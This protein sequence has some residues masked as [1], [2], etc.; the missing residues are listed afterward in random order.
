MTEDNNVVSFRRM[1]EGTF[2]DYALLERLEEDF[3]KRLPERILEHVRRLE[4]TLSGYQVT[5]LEHSLQAATR[6]RRDGADTDW[7]VAALLHDIGDDLAP[8]NHDSLAAD[9]LKPYVREEVTWVIR[10]HGIFQLAHFGDKVGADPNARDKY[11]DSP[12]YD[13]AVTFCAR[14]DQLAFDPD[15]D[16][17]PL[18]SFAPLVRD[19]FARE[20]WAQQHLQPGVQVPL[21][22][23]AA[24]E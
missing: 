18:D 10:H 16:S 21:V 12:H 4:H 7:V 3:A 9:V 2:E 6:A 23:A 19:V 14:W 5:R 11:A 13:A 1:D 20:P 17:D 8:H 22:R 15:Y 24:A